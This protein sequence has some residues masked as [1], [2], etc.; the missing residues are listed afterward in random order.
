MQTLRIP[1]T[2]A[3][4]VKRFLIGN[5]LLD[6]GYRFDKDDKF[7]YL[8]ITEEADLKKRFPETRIMRHALQPSKKR[9]GLRQLLRK[10]LTAEEFARLKT[11]F[12][13]VGDI[14]I[15]EIDPALRKKEKV[16]AKALLETTPTIKTVLR[17]AEK[18]TGVFRTQKLRWLAGRKTKEALYREN[19]IRLKLD[20]EKVY[21]SPRLSTERKRIAQLIRKGEDVLVMFSGCGPYPCV[22]AKNTDAKSITG[23]EINPV[24]HAYASENI[25]LNKLINVKVIEGDVR[26]VM[27]K[28]RTRYDRILMPLPMGAGEF[29]DLALGAAKKGATV[30]FYDFLKE[31]NIPAAA[32]KKIRDACKKTG[33]RCIIKGHV[34]CG[35]F[36]PGIF[37]VCVDFSVQ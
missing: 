8:P 25:K 28:M 30:H 1:L 33:R 2:R 34:K 7:L 23:I 27:P 32:V 12:D 17:K 22:L 3:E 26:K 15:M 31:E 37:R 16:I 11:A 36:G 29:L 18:H 9:P 20:V 13:M 5:S 14:A 10:R 6:K 4:E 21:F 35:Q 19:G 24:A